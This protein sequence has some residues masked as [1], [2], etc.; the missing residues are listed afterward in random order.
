MSHYKWYNELYLLSPTDVLV[1]HGVLQHVFLEHRWLSHWS[2]NQ[3]FK[4]LSYAYIYFSVGISAVVSARMLPIWEHSTPLP[5]Q[6]P[7]SSIGIGA[8]QVLIE[9][10]T[11]NGFATQVR[12]FQISPTINQSN[13]SMQRCHSVLWQFAKN[14]AV[15]R[16]WEDREKHLL[17]RNEL[18][19]T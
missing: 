15:T 7:N 17:M 16:W 11:Q 10:I 13:T 4:K 18:F 6:V 12:L 8:F 14:P 9:S 1:L 2:K 5:V 3:Y 19:K